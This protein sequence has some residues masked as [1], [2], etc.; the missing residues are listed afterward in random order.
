VPRACTVAELLA[1]PSIDLVI[2][3]TVPQAHVAV[4]EAAL[5]AGKHVYLEKPFALKPAEGARVLKLAKSRGLLIACAPDTFLGGGIQT[6]LKLVNEGAIGKPIS[7]MAFWANRGHETWHPAP[8]FYYQKGGGPNFDM[9]PYYLTALVALMGPVKSVSGFARKTFA[10]RT[11]TSQ[12][13]AGQKI[14]VEVPT[15]Y[16]GT[17]EFANGAIASLTVSFD[18]VSFP[19]PR[20]VVYGTDGTLEVPDPNRFDGEVRI[21]RLGEKEFSPVP[22]THSHDRGRG[23][24]VADLAYSILRKKRPVRASGELAQHVVEIMAAFDTAAEK[25]RVVSIKSA[26]KRP[27]P[28]PVGLGTNE[29]DA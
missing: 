28:L 4:N 19:L 26:P 23:T 3:L 11:I 10:Q 7:A 25:R 13:R 18:L 1:D 5:R 27:V 14:R 22:A 20:I 8:D 15:H 17:L 24:G 6:A 12:P 2:N 9:S 29:L 21:R 16:M